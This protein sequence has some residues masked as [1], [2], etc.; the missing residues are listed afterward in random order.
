MQTWFGLSDQAVFSHTAP[1]FSTQIRLTLWLRQHLYFM[2]LQ[3]LEVDKEQDCGTQ[4]VQNYVL[5]YNLCSRELGNTLHPGFSKK[6]SNCVLLL[7][8][9][10]LP[11]PVAWCAEMLRSQPQLR[12]RDA[13]VIHTLVLY[14]KSSEKSSPGGFRLGSCSADL[15]AHLPNDSIMISHHRKVLL[16]WT[17]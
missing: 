13:S 9:S 2:L 5:G 17:S 8:R 14:S 12:Q 1:S 15:D 10:W 11:S 16:K 7:S 6:G 4:K 3:K